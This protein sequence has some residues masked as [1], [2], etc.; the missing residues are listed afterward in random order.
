MTSRIVCRNRVGSSSPNSS[1]SRS[2]SRLSGSHSM[3]GSQESLGTSSLNGSLKVPTTSFN[4]TSSLRLGLRRSSSSLCLQDMT[5]TS[6]LASYENLKH[7]ERYI[8]KDEDLGNVAGHKSGE[9]NVG[10]W[11]IFSAS[12]DGSLRYY[13]NGN[14]M[15]ALLF[16]NLE[17]FIAPR[18]LQNTLVVLGLYYQSFAFLALVCFLESTFVRLNKKFHLM[19]FVKN[20]LPL[21]QSTWISSF[22]IDQSESK[23]SADHWFWNHL[24]KHENPNVDDNHFT[25]TVSANGNIAN[26]TG[27][28]LKKIPSDEWGHFADFDESA[29]LTDILQQNQPFSSMHAI[30]SIATNHRASINNFCIPANDAAHLGTLHESAEGDDD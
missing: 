1:H 13:G 12:S 25:S 22:G 17:G 7:Q 20:L 8:H 29:L 19:T 15:S 2:L 28:G 4:G 23:E 18:W 3:L 27:G 30:R 6:S 26:H 21:F 11:K 10:G 16:N 14:T 24:A 9:R 5:S